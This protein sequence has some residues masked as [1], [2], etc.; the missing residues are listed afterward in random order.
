MTGSTSLGIRLSVMMFLQ[1]AVWGVWSPVVSR[2]LQAGPHEG[3][4]GF[5]A[6]Q[7]GWILGLGASVGAIAAP[8]VAGQIADRHLR[9]DRCLAV[10]I[11]LGGVVK[12]VTAYQTGFA[13]WLL[14][15]ILYSVLFIPTLALTNSICF[16]HLDDPTHQFPRIRVWGTIGW[17]AVAWAFPMIWLQT[18]LTFSWLPPFFAGNEVPDVT[19]RL[20][21]SLKAAGMISIALWLYCAV[22]LPK[23]S[24]RRDAVEALAF[25]KALRLLRKRSFALLVGASV[26][27]SAI[28]TVY[29]I[30][31]APFLVSIGL[32]DSYILPAMSVG[33]IAE[34]AVLAV[35]GFLLKGL[36]FRA[37]ITVGAL[38]YFLRFAVFGTVD[39]PVGVIIASQ[40]L[41]GLC[42]ACFF[43]AAYIYVDRLAD[44]DVRHS[45]QAVF[46]ITILGLGPIL[47]GWLNGELAGLSRSPEGELDYSTFWYTVAIIGLGVAVL[48][49]IFFRDE[50]RSQ[51][52]GVRIQESS[53]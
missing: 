30:Q 35:L 16:A 39:L 20:V 4:L 14:L 24:P 10:L 13:A 15:S 3:G 43:A 53:D 25:A 36:G 18:D 27:I 32:R 51:E 5:S 41:H 8:F 11:L 26:I 34:I 17:I 21:D 38:A 6:G 31:T 50:S 2:Y 48:M 52:S 1:Y 49:A 46:S 47:G 7:V 28:H 44:E 40:T 23:T 19:S 29:F 22:I 12:W 37:V 33:Q 45:V 9:A 42:Y